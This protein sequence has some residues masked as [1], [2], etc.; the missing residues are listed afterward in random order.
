MS[1]E[2]WS[3]IETF[4]DRISAEAL[5]GLFESEKLPCQI[6]SNE[7][8][9]GLGRE[10]AVLVPAE[11]VARAKRIREQA[12]H[13]PARELAELATGKRGKRSKR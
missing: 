4:G 5:A 10:F 7:I 9:P 12:A 3:V 2:G 1:S 6:A 8:V 11:C 13:I